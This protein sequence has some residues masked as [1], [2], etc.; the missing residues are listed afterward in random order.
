MHT[1]TIR[2]PIGIL[3]ITTD[4]KHLQAI[5]FV[6]KMQT[7]GKASALLQ[8]TIKEL[9][10]YFQ[11]KRTH[12]TIPM[13]VDGTAFQTSVWKA[14]QSIKHGSTKTYS[15]IAKKIGKSKAVRAVGTACGRN[16]LAI[17]VPCHRVKAVS[18]LGGYSGGL[19]KK[20]WLLD[21]EKK[22]N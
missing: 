18:G 11:G 22:A 12:F 8:K 6:T 3:K 14:M 9:Q 16:P 1:A 10:E 17:I 21:H 13:K 15:E 2:S 20:K 5:E 4:E 7:S 19:S